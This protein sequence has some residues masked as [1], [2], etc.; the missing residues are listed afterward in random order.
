MAGGLG[1]PSLPGKYV[2]APCRQ[3][4]VEA[5]AKQVVA[6]PFITGLMHQ[7]QERQ[8]F[9]PCISKRPGH[10]TL[11]LGGAIIH[12][13]QQTLTRLAF[14]GKGQEAVPG[15]VAVPGRADFQELPT[16]VPYSGRFRKANNLR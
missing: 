3:I 11:A 9:S 6:L 12:G 16:P 2:E 4:Q 1:P 10:V 8:L 13:N 14:P 5:L 15:G 7:V